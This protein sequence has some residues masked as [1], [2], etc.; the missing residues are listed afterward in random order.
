MP[1]PVPSTTYRRC[2]PTIF[3]ANLVSR[4][5]EYGTQQVRADVNGPIIPGV[6]RGGVA[7]NFDNSDGPYQDPI[8]NVR[9]GQVKKQDY[10]AELDFTP[11][12]ELDISA[13]YYIGRDHFG[14]DPIVTATPNCAL[15][16][17]GNICGQYIANPIRSPTFPRPP[18]T[19]ATTAMCRRPT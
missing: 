11:T 8:T 1:L 12:S 13:G 7:V 19:P 18:A 16:G 5:G 2:P 17:G 4:I 6:L 3:E 10:K 14:Q 9:A 15:A